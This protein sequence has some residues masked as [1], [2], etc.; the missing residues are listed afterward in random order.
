MIANTVTWLAVV[1]QTVSACGTGLALCI[2]RQGEVRLEVTG[3]TCAA[4]ADDACRHEQDDAHECCAGEEATPP[5]EPAH[6]WKDACDCL[7]LDFAD[8]TLAAI[9]RQACDPPGE[10]FA[11]F[12][13]PPPTLIAADSAGVACHDAPDP[14]HFASH[15]AMLRS[16][17]LRC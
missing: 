17:M 4:C 1:A 3:A 14:H 9:L 7:H 6:A 5:A 8:A 12:D 16:V 10:A 11:A 15:F 13:A 2:S